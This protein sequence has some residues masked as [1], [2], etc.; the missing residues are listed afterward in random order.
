MVGYSR[1]LMT[2]DKRLR[3]PTMSDAQVEQFIEEG[4]VRL[5]QAFPRQL[6]EEGRAIMWRDIPCD[7]HDPAT[8]TRPVIRLAGYGQEPFR[9]AAKRKTSSSASGGRRARP[10]A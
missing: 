2:D 5:D 3:S 8:W 10:M 6:A 7:P 9:K 1:H 4:F